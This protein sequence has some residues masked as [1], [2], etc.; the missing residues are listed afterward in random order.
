VRSVLANDRGGSARRLSLCDSEFSPSKAVDF[1]LDPFD[2]MLRDV[3][4][5]DV[6]VER[7]WLVGHSLGGFLVGRY[8]M[9]IH[10]DRGAPSSS[11]SSTTRTT[12]TS[13]TPNVTKIVLA[14]P[15]GFRSLPPPPRV[16]ISSSSSAPAALRLVDALWS[17]NLTPQAIVRLMGHA[18]G[19]DAVRRALG[20]RIPH[21]R[22]SERELLAEYLYHVTV[23]PPSGEYA[24]NSLME[25]G[26]S[27]EDGSVGVYAL[28]SLGDGAMAGAF[29]RFRAR[30]SSSTLGSV[31]VLFG[32]ADWMAF[33]EMEAR[34]EMGRIRTECGIRSAVHV[35]P[36]SGHHLYLDNPESFGRHIIED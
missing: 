29:S 32:D 23:A 27:M 2:S 4:L 6:G 33:H 12:S 10:E 34:R 15:V 17:A 19:R 18:R 30:S 14:S 9:R 22:D 20:G 7:L 25:P 26:W 28:E 11:S 21:L 24:M 8:A 13:T 36:S 31:K 5:F 16:R 3:A 35:V 1:F